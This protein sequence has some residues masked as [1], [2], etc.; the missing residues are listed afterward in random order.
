MKKLTVC[1][2]MSLLLVGVYG[3]ASAHYGMVIPSDSMVMQ[4]ENKVVKVTL[5]F[6]HPFEGHGMELVKPGVL[7]V[8]ANGK[9]ADLLGKLK[10]T[11]VM[12]HTAWTADYKINRPGVYMF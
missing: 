5:S 6:S 2:I 12:G 7:G 8:M 10:K 9:K 4:G 1:L 11:K 3:M